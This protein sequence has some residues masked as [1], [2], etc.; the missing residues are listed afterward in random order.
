LD[1][2]ETLQWPGSGGT[3][4]AFDGTADSGPTSRKLR[5][6]GL[7]PVGPGFDAQ[8][9]HRYAAAN[10]VRLHHVI[11]GPEAGPLVVL[12]HDWPQ[13]LVHLAP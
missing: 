1:R 2:A 10:G 12:L 6:G 5:P 7:W 13:D 3:D 4:P 8:F 11:G 9:E